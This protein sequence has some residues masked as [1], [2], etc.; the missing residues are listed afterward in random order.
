VRLLDPR[1]NYVPAVATD[2]GSTF[3]RFGFNPRANEERRARAR[4]RVSDVTPPTQSETP[5][6]RAPLRLKA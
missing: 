6:I 1:F 5:S 2:V 4:R 3:R